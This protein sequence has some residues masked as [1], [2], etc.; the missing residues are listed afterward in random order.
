MLASHGGE[1]DVEL[2][3]VVGTAG[4]VAVALALPSLA[5]S[6]SLVNQ[7]VVSR[8]CLDGSIDRASSFHLDLPIHHRRVI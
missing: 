4:P 1:S 3:E 8:S 7:L 6:C 5:S 2:L